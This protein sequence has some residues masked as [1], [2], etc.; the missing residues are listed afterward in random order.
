M[1]RKGEDKMD[2]VLS[3]ETLL[4]KCNSDLPQMVLDT[5][6]FEQ[7]D[8]YFVRKIDSIRFFSKVCANITNAQMALRNIRP[9]NVL[10]MRMLKQGNTICF[11]VSDYEQLYK[12]TEDENEARECFEEKSKIFSLLYCSK[13]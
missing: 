13:D 10:E 7:L 2:E 9:V 4:A 11:L 1:L 8:T 6:I 3:L 5:N 12:L